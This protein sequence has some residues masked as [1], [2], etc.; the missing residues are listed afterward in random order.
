MSSV[1]RSERICGIRM[2]IRFTGIS[3]IEGKYAIVCD[4]PPNDLVKVG[5][6]SMGICVTTKFDVNE[7]HKVLETEQIREFDTLVF[8]ATVKH[9]RY[10]VVKATDIVVTE[11]IR[12]SPID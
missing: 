11:C 7:Y 5:N 1:D 4:Y 6:D 10:G 3:K 2:H 12:S 9:D 8:D